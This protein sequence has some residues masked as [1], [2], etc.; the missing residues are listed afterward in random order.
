[1]TQSS[2]KR[3]AYRQRLPGLTVLGALSIL[4]VASIPVAM[5]SARIFYTGRIS[6]TFLLW[7]LF[8][9]WIPFLLALLAFWFR[10]RPLLS[11]TLGGLW[12]LFLPNAPY[13]VTDLMHLRPT[14]LAPIWFDATMLFAFALAGMALGLYSLYLMQELVC[15]R[16]G[17]AAGWMLVIVAASLSSFGVYIGRFLRWNSWDLFFN[18][19][20]LAADIVHNLAAPESLLK[21]VVVVGLFTVLTIAGHL[22]VGSRRLISQPT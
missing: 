1:M 9:A 4:V 22:L 12:L 7:N 14:F 19:T 18:P 2:P 3:L 6:H 8:L 20:R 21:M 16:F 13:L 15:L 17:A 10:Q 11:L 5:L